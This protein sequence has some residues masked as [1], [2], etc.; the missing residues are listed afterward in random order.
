MQSPSCGQ[1]LYALNRYAFTT[2][3]QEH[4]AIA[5]Y[6]GTKVHRATGTVPLNAKLRAVMRVHELH[7]P[8]MQYQHMTTAIS[9]VQG[10][11]N[12]VAIFIHNSF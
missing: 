5:W 3:K 4:A 7:R 11:P 9:Y 1:I 10:P 2:K 6:N 8:A 12:L